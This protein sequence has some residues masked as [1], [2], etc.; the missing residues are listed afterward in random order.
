MIMDNQVEIVPYTHSRKGVLSM[1]KT[2]A[3][4]LLVLLTL[5]AAVPAM[6]ASQLKVTRQGTTVDLKT[7]GS[8]QSVIRSGGRDVTVPSSE[9]EWESSADVRFA[10]IYAPTA[11][12]VNRRMA[13][14]AKASIIDK[15]PTGRIVMVFEKNDAWSGVYYDGLTGYVQNS[16]LR[17]IENAEASK[18]TATLSYKGDTHVTTKVTMRSG[19]S[20]S[21][22]AVV[23]LRPG[24]AVTVFSLGKTWSEVE[25]NGYHGFVLTVHLTDIRDAEV[26]E[27][28]SGGAGDEPDD[29]PVVIDPADAPETDPLSAMPAPADD[30]IPLIEEEIDLD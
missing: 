26:L 28:A 6:A 14:R 18:A 19:A 2:L 3:W 25:V 10:Y 23:G 20:Q 7:I 17:F 9:L 1:K 12:R 24:M 27:D 21:S 5:T 16:T 29:G 13:G 8:W 4:A 15:I 22:R 11:G 30:S